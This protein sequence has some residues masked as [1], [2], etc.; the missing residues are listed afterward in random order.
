MC[1]FCHKEFLRIKDLRIHVDEHPRRIVD[2]CQ[3]KVRYSLEC[4]KVEISCLQCTICSERVANLDSLKSHL[5]IEHSKI[6]DPD[7]DDGFMPYLINDETFTC[8]HCGIYYTSFMNL[9][10]H[11][12]VHY[13]KHICDVCGKGFSTRYQLQCHMAVHDSGEFSCNK[14]NAVFKNRSLR[15]SHM[16]NIHRTIRYK[17]PHCDETFAMYRH[18][19]KH[20]KEIHDVKVEY[21]CPSCTAVFDTCVARRKHVQKVHVGIYKTHV[22]SECSS[23]FL[24]SGE[25]KNHMV[26]HGGE[27]IYECTFC[28]KS[29]ARQKT[30]KEHLR[31][32]YND[33]RF[34]C[35]VCSQAFVQ[36]C[37]LKQHMRVHHPNVNAV[38]KTE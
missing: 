7:K 18:R 24:T 10:R 31:I 14:C 28:H 27:K 3:R 4:H 33:R 1:A 6:F 29:Y 2:L 9:V 17:C 8:V 23:T 20:L 30:L 5:T 34:V 35:A 37:S 15:N 25:L 13:Q 16:A 12:N 22:C 32:H 36:N 21:R 19:T 38:C 11:N 26:K